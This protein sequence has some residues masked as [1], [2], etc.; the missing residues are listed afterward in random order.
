MIR[1]DVD[2]NTCALILTGIWVIRIY[3]FLGAKI[4]DIVKTKARWV[5]Y[6]TCPLRERSGSYESSLRCSGRWKVYIFGRKFPESLFVR[7]YGGD[8]SK[9]F[10]TVMTVGMPMK[11][12]E[13]ITCVVIPLELVYELQFIFEVVELGY[14]FLHSHFNF[15][16]T[17]C[18]CETVNQTKQQ[19]FDS[20]KS[21][22]RA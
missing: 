19:L 10:I 7:H 5:L 6:T 9:C 18:L 15:S 22:T 17:N 12:A 21:H 11:P 4:L 16:N 3:T 8:L 14:H 20:Q 13:S 1:I 2:E